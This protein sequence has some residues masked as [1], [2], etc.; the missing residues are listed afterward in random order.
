MKIPHSHP[1]Y[2]QGNNLFVTTKNDTNSN[3]PHLMMRSL[4]NISNSLLYLYRGRAKDSNFL[5]MPSS[6]QECYRH[7]TK[8]HTHSIHH[9]VISYGD[10]APCCYMTND[11]VCSDSRM[12]QN[13]QCI[14]QKNTINEELSTRETLPYVGVSTGPVVAK[15]GIKGKNFIINLSNVITI[16]TNKG[17]YI[18]DGLSPHTIY[19]QLRREV[20]VASQLGQ[21]FDKIDFQQRI[22][23]K[24]KQR[25]SRF[26]ANATT[27]EK[28]GAFSAFNSSTVQKIFYVR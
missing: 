20:R 6:A 3:P 25:I 10:T 13:I 4:N 24:A 28:I 22:N 9:R 18:S 12:Q 1:V 11:R 27:I 19:A 5:A 26:Y 8:T 15:R 21:Y 14:P 17:I 2:F 16:L 23:F 7:A